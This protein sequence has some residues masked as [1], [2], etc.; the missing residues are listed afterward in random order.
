[1][2]FD[3]DYPIPSYIIANTVVFDGKSMHIPKQQIKGCKDEIESQIVKRHLMNIKGESYMLHFYWTM[4][5]RIFVKMIKVSEMLE[6]TGYLG[7]DV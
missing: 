6:Y 3:K 2:K 1:M 5:K 7:Y 4:E